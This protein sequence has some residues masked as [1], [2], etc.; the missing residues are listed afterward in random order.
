MVAGSSRGGGLRLGIARLF[1]TARHL[2]SGQISNRI[3]RRFA[4]IGRFKGKTPEL[5]NPR[6]AW[7]TH[8]PLGP[9]LV[10]D[11]LANFLNESG[12][13]FE[14]ENPHKSKLWLYN[15]HYFDDLLAEGC[16]HRAAL[17]REY[18]Q[19]WLEDNE[20]AWRRRYAAAIR[21][22]CRTLAD[23]ADRSGRIPLMPVNRNK[24]NTDKKVARVS[25]MI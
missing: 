12:P 16:E 2:K 24:H 20:E 23:A 4:R 19:Q 21:S 11:G 6:Q 14:W 5:R 17:H 25:L 15:L 3:F 22:R 7:Q 13:L 10:V 1:N 9:L 18:I 8:A